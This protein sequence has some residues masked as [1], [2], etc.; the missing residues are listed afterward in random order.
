MKKIN[1]AG[2]WNFQLDPEKQGQ[3]DMEFTDTIQLPATTAMA[4]KGVVN[5]C[6]EVGYLTE[7]YPFSGYAW[8]EKEIVLSE[9]EYKRPIKLYLERTR[10]SKVWVNGHYIGQNDSLSTPHEYELSHWITS[11]VKITICIDNTSYVTKGGHLTSRDT[12]TNWNGI[13]GAIELRVY[14]PIYLEA[15]FVLPNLHL[16]QVTSE[17]RIINS[18]HQLLETEFKLELTKVTMDREVKL[19]TP[20]QTVSWMLKPGTNDCSLTYKMDHFEPW[21]EYHPVCYRLELVSSLGEVC[22]MIEFG[23]REFRA[24]HHH[25]YLNGNKTFL[26]GKHDGLIFP[27]TGATPTSLT[28]WIRIFLIAKEYG[29]NHYR[30]HTC[31]PPETAFMA[32]DLTGMYLEPELPFWGTITS[33]EDEDHQEVEQNYLIEEGKRMLKAYG[34][35]PSFMMFSLGNELWGSKE[36]ISKMIGEFK[37]VDSRPLYTQGSNNFQFA[38]VIL[39]AEDFFVGVRFSRD[40]LIRG[41]YAMCDA[42]LGFVQ[43]QVPGT[44]YSFDQHFLPTQ[45]EGSSEAGLIEEIEIQYETGTKRV[46]KEGEGSWIPNKPVIAHETGQ[47]AMYP[48]FREIE[49][50]TGVLKARNFEVFKERLEAAGMLEQAELFF[51]A[52]GQLAVQCYKLE[53][54]AAFRSQYLAGFQLLDL[55]DFS[56]QGTAL[57]GILDAFMDSKGLIEAKKWRQFC[58]DLVVMAQMDSFIYEAG[59]EFQADILVSCYR[60]HAQLQDACNWKLMRG[61]EV[62]ARGQI[63]GIHL[64]MGVTGVGKVAFNLPT[65]EE[66]SKLTLEITLENNEVMNQYDLWI[67]PRK[68]LFPRK[69]WIT[70]QVEEAKTWLQEGKKVLLVSDQIKSSLEGFYC[71]DFWCYPMFRSIS[72][73]VNKPIPHGTLGL[74]INDQHPALKYFPSEFYSTPQWY[75][76]V[77]NSS[78]AILNETPDHYSPIVQV[79]DNFERNHKLGLLFEAK[80]GAGSLLVCTC[81]RE[82]LMQYPEGRQ[83]LFS[84]AQYVVS[85]EFKPQFDDKDIHLSV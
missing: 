38:P 61:H 42:P 44:G 14:P 47:Y 34:N 78:F 41:S 39:D 2:L 63:E 24:D 8:F 72:E 19:E 71:T 46:L 74:L 15:A 22:G 43:T 4:R 56:G 50:Y 28:E 17:L 59:A 57:V 21:D 77:T 79:I 40:R 70:N 68:L 30:Y 60:P 37:A 73:K 69:N 84:L 26:R 66:A 85:E 54:E 51:Q 5:D 49:K 83:F 29:I 52:S 27:L 53:M 11:K 16:A 67:Y 64:E 81:D 35:H 45:N 20:E 48:N 82:K 9:E 10:I 3:I 13:V 25:F 58:W 55:Q 75:Q 23:M 80:V 32:A 62:V 65:I 12:Q 33:T 6:R 18:Y 76:I 36:Q 31:C 7:E 1:L